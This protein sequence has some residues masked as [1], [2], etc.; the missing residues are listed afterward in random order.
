M[1]LFTVILFSGSCLSQ[2]LQVLKYM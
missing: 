2:I 1:L